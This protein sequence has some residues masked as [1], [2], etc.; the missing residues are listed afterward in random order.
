METILSEII[1]RLQ[2][3][4]DAMREDNNDDAVNAQLDSLYDFVSNKEDEAARTAWLKSA[5]VL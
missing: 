4:D 5:G 2:D 3:I 1:D